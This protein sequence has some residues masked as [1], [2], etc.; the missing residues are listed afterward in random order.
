MVLLQNR[1][2]ILPLKPSVR[3]IAVIGPSADDPM[4]PRGNLNYSGVPSHLV[5]PLEAV[6]RQFPAAQVSYALGATY[7]RNIPALVPPTVLTAP[8]GR[9]EGLEAEY[10]DNLDLQGEPKLRRTEAHVNFEREMD[11][12]AVVA[13]VG[14]SNYAIRWTGTLTAPATGE[15]GLIARTGMWNRDGQ[16]RLFLDGQELKFPARPDFHSPP[17]AA[18]AAPPSSDAGLPPVNGDWRNPQVKMHLEAGR[19]YAVRIEYTQNGPGGSAEFSWIPPLD[20]SVAE[21]ERVARNADLALV[22]VGLN[23]Q[24]EGET[25]DRKDIDLPEPQ[26]KLVEAVIATGKPTVVV[27]TGGSAISAK[28]AAE[29]AA[30]LLEAWYGGEEAGTAIVETLTG[31]NNPAGRLPVTFY[32]SADQLPAMTDYAMKG[33]TYRYF[34]G[35]PLFSFGFGLS[36]SSFQYSS[37]RTQRTANGAEISATVKNTSTRDGDE[38]VQLYV[39]DPAGEE[40][41]NLRGFERIHLRAGESRSVRFTLSADVLPK[42]KLEV[43]VGGGQPLGTIP[44]VQG[45]L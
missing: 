32:K 43:N 37:L 4:A 27:L 24:L 16:V 34:K 25:F 44:H 17:P 28:Y 9:N 29:H 21:A 5:T 31:A 6:K 38:V 18:L 2:G 39:S 15:Y 22:F 10:F 1:S 33:H 14:E 3:R 36:Y 19:K 13:A 40:I 20:T 45:V 12:P 11:D 42:S 41:R 26:E 35:D 23:T 8:D 30:A 7:A